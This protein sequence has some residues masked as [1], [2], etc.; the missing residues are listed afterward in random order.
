MPD[1]AVVIS[2]YE[3]EADL[4]HCLASVG[5]QSLTPS[6]VL[7]VDAGSSDASVDVARANGA[8]AMVVEN[9]GLGHLYNTGV[10]AVDSELVFLANADVALHERCLEHLS[11][12]LDA[13]DRWA[14][15]P[16]QLDWSG[17]RVIHARTTLG[18]GSLRDLIPFVRIDPVAP[19]DGVVPTFAA[20]A[21]AMLVRRERMLELGGFDEA[22]FMDYEDVDL[23]WRAWQ[24]GWAS[25]YV[26]SAVVRH[27]VGAS[28]GEA[29]ARRRRISAHH[30]M[31][32]F[33]LKCLPPHLAAAV[34]A[35]EILRALAHPRI[36]GTA[37]GGVARAL[38]EILRERRRLR[39]SRALHRWLVE[40]QLGPPPV[41]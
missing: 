4:P 9:R 32:R 27:R 40:G 39:P 7:V 3:N 8:E 33:A 37:L 21:G 24:R 11:A 17:E 36:V 1:V 15:D 22:F 13:G 10:R 41:R 34:V 35:G 25:V 38:P 31:V 5:A 6:R 30:N 26:P 28:T 16:K 19:S 20:N 29:S 2:S 23:S 12:A 18:R 14:A